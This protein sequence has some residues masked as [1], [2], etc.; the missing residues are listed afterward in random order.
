MKKSWTNGITTR[1]PDHRVLLIS[2]LL[3]ATIAVL[4]CQKNPA[5]PDPISAN[6]TAQIPFQKLSG[7]IAFRRVL[8]KEPEQFYFMLL[9]AEQQTIA[10][11]ASFNI[12][13]PT[14]LLLS[15]DG[16]RMLFSYFVYKGQTRSFVWQMY[17][18]E[19]PIRLI[20][21]VA[22][23]IYDDSF[24]AWSPDG[25]KIAFWSNR[26]LQSA[27]WL[28]DLAM[29][30]SYKLVNVDNMARTRPSW[31]ADGMNLVYA[32]SDSNNKSTFYQYHIGTS[33]SETIYSDELTTTDLIFK[34]P[35]ISPDDRWLA[36]V[37]SH[38]NGVDEIWI[39]DFETKAITRVT[40]GYSDWHPAWSPDGAKLL[41]SRGNYLFIINRDG[42]DLTQVTFHSGAIDEY[43]SWIP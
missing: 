35:I 31:R 38:K 16:I 42:T 28:V 14:N 15:P 43:P 24:G 3:T 11:F 2:I 19:I 12:Y 6:E 26:D 29:D 4:S 33:T 30:S 36:F 22:P 1:M 23:S 17:I 39:F 21:N 20:R 34:H 40:T 37:K 25:K 41:F 5:A 7:K 10:P 32:S 18:L 13:V 27:I 8:Q 9:D